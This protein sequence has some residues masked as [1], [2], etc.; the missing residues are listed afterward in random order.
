MKTFVAAVLGVA[1]FTAPLA[2]QTEFWASIDGTQETPTVVTD[3]GGWGHF[4]LN[5]G[6]NTLDYEVHVF[7]LGSP[8]TNV[9]LH[10]GAPGSGGPIQ[11]VLIGGPND[12]VG[13]T[14]AL[15]PVQMADLAA[16]DW[17]V[18][19]HTTGN[20]GGE[21]RGQVVPS[22]NEFG[23]ALDGTQEVPPNASP[24]T[25]NAT[26]SLNPN[27]TITY[28]VTATGLVGALNNGHIHAAPF[29]AN[30]PIDVALTTT[31]PNTLSGTSPPLSSAAIE[32][33]QTQGAYINMH[34]TAFPAGEVRGQV[35]PSGIRYNPSTDPTTQTAL[36]YSTGAPVDNPVFDGT[37]FIHLE[38][39]VPF[40]SFVMLGSIFP[41]AI[42][43]NVEPFA[44]DPGTLIINVT[45]PLDPLGEL[46]LPVATPPVPFG[47]ELHLQAFVLDPGAPNGKYN[48]SNGLKLPI[49]KF[50]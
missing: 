44:L 25:A 33:L 35:V 10:L 24:A 4:T 16:G 48:A 45:L 30:G 32:R 19:I 49:S 18:N 23:A 11:H 46:H 34:T 38:N 7:G 9:H 42:L 1:L 31:G 21:I 6:P 43:L 13:T 37:F 17:Y 41:D 36:L 39:G 28:N 8:S 20:P 2:A 50:P 47:I 5:V 40:G 26:I 12:W 27:G 3:G 29:G 22:P 14:L 15:T